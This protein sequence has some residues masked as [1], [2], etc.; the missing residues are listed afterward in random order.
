MTDSHLDEDLELDD[1][2]NFSFMFCQDNSQLE[3]VLPI[4]GSRWV[5]KE[6][7]IEL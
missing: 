1:N 7:D 2:F 4:K 6:P 3:G 5:L